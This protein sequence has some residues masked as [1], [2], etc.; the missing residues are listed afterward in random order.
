[1][2]CAIC[3]GA[4]TG[5]TTHVCDPDNLDRFYSAMRSGAKVEPM[6]ECPSCRAHRSGCKLCGD[7][8]TVREQVAR[9]WPDTP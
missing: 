9:D 1:M 5:M 2:R 7:S 4:L 6:V 3:G 8:G